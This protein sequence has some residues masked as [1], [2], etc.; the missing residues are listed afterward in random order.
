MMFHELAGGVIINL[1]M[2]IEIDKNEGTM[3]TGDGAVW[4]LNDE[5]I[6]AIIKRIGL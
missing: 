2:I 1:S 6:D 5:E 4:N 3:V